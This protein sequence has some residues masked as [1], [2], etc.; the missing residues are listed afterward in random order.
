MQGGS[1][2]RRDFSGL[3]FIETEANLGVDLNTGSCVG[4]TVT[5]LDSK[6]PAEKQNTQSLFLPSLP[7]PPPHHAMKPGE[8]CFVCVCSTLD[9]CK[10]AE[11]FNK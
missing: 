8:G 4:E 2:E 5:T 11:R 7:P 1:G 3:V 6:K 10:R 9:L